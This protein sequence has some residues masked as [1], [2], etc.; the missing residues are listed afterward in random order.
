MFITIFTPTFNRAHTLE[1]LYLS[2]K[3]QRNHNFEW[4]VVDD[5]SNDGTRGLVNSWI[6]S[7]ACDFPIRYYFQKN[8]GKHVAW[9]KG[10]EEARGDIFFPVDSD[11]YLT[12]NA[13]E[14]IEKMVNTVD[15]NDSIIA[16]SGVRSFPNDQLTGGALQTMTKPYIDYSSINR[17]SKGITGDLAEAFFTEKLRRYPFPVIP[18]EKFVPEAVIFNRFS[19]DGLMIRGFSAPLYCCEYLSDGYTRH[20]DK[21]LIENWK[22]YSLYVKELMSS[23]V[24]MKAKVIPLCGYIYRW[25]AKS[26][27]LKFLYR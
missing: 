15:Q 3:D 2:I 25:I 11:D 8:S 17:R 13:I 7:K 24:E 27:H 4:I 21:L 1:R 19:N 18:E 26:F 12:A 16:V 6:E 10:L 23:P 20:M 14:L 22:G 9:N 5:G